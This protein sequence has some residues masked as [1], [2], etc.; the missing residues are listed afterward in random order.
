MQAA[1]VGGHTMT[2]QS[3]LRDR[4]FLAIKDLQAPLAGNLY[5][6]QAVEEVEEDDDTYPQC[7]FCGEF[8]LFHTGN[9]GIAHTSECAISLI[10]RILKDGNLNFFDQLAYKS[11]LHQI[12]NME[13]YPQKRVPGFLDW[14]YFCPFCQCIM[15]VTEQRYQDGREI[16]ITTTY[17]M[18]HA[19]NCIVTL[20][21]A[22]LEQQQG[23][24]A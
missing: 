18:P 19:E 24:K 10:H 2:N 8:G 11:I 23:G 1:V 17:A 9:G 3:T 6:Y 7:H 13:R 12:A 22:E 14:Q 20:A 16:T 21:K 4:I 5:P 15:E